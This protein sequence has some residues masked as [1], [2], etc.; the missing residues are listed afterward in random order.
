MP[1][2]IDVLACQGSN[3]LL[4]DGAA[5]VFTGYYVVREYESVFPGI[6]RNRLV[7]VNNLQNKPAPKVAQKRIFPENIPNREEKPEKKPI[8]N[9]GKSPYSVVIKQQPELS[10]E[11]QAIAALLQKQPQPMDD[12]LAPS[13][14]PAG[15]TTSLLTM[16]AIKG[17]VKN[18]PGGLV[19]LI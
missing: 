8:D 10:G 7:T 13:P 15:K 12:V 1:G 9:G 16:L 19:S 14:Y 3:A 4:Q 17:G 11:E 18:Y 6:V 5:A 2:N